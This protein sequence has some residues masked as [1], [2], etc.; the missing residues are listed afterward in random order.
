MRKSKAK[1]VSVNIARPIM[2][3]GSQEF[4][5]VVKNLV[6]DCEYEFA[7]FIDDYATGEDILG[8]YE[9]VIKTFS[10]DLF[11]IAI[12]IGYKNLIARWQ[13][14]QKIL[15]DGYSTPSLVHERAYV[16]RTSVVG[17]GAIVMAGAIIDAFAEVQELTVLWPGVVVNHNSVIGANTFLSPN[18]TVCG[19]SR[20]GQ[21]CFVG[22]GAVI[23][24]HRSVADNAYIKAGSLYK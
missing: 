3:Y 10:P 21:S 15:A 2:V 23:V 11:S 16:S 4:G 13:V 24:D 5:S 19:F 20:V 17:Q 9:Y 18:S 1:L 14:Y 12:A 22:A 8:A 7:G 6:L